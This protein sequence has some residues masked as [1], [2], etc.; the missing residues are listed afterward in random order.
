MRQSQHHT[1]FLSPTKFTGG[2]HSGGLAC[3]FKRDIHLP[4]PLLFYSEFFFLPVSVGNVVFISSY[5]PYEGYSTRFLVKFAKVCGLLKNLVNQVLSNSLQYIIIGDLNTDINQS[6]VSDSVFECLPS[7]CVVPKSRK[8]SYVHHSGSTSDID[9]I[10]CSP[11]II[12][13]SDSVHVNE[14][15]TDHMPISVTFRM[16]IN[17]LKTN[18]SREKSRW[19]EKIN[20]SK[21]NI[22]HYISTLTAL[23]STIRVPYH[24]LRNVFVKK[25]KKKKKPIWSMDP[26]LKPIK[27]KRKYGSRYEMNAVDQFLCVW[28]ISN[29]KL[30]PNLSV[31]CG[32][33]VTAV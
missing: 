25:K 22:P 2:H 8:F 23:L 15:D 16:D 19:F 9:H 11:G 24:L 6:S 12:S 4:S 31:I 27:I 28:L 30:K 7:Y 20:W 5:I 33:H 14:Q 18:F 21:A 26:C 29:V 13:S 17:L 10:I 1:A 3:V 32:Q